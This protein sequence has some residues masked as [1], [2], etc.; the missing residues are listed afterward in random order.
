MSTRDHIVEMLPVQEAGNN[1]TRRMTGY[2]KPDSIGA[3]MC[4]GDQIARRMGRMNAGNDVAGRMTGPAP[5]DTGNCE[6]PGT[7]Q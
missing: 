1:I 5:G 6:D 2:G 3:I 7:D 4:T